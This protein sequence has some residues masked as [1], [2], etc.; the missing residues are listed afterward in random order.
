M[1]KHSVDHNHEIDYEN[2]AILDRARNDRELLLKEMLYINKIKP[3]MN[4][5]TNSALFSLLI[6]NKV[7]K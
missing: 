7:V 2:Y 5:Q 6:G 3:S 1:F 4:V